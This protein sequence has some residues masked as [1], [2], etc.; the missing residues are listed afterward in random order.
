MH[1]ESVTTELH[2]EAGEEPHRYSVQIQE[3]VIKKN[4]NTHFIHSTN[5]NNYPM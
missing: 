1:C 4:N 3:G 2:H 5:L